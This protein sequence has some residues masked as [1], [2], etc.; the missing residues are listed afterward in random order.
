MIKEFFID[1]ALPLMFMG[2][3]IIVIILCAVLIHDIIHDM[4]KERKK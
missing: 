4:L 1:V 3:G 2:L